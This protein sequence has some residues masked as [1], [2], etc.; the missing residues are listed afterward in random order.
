[1]GHIARHLHGSSHLHLAWQLASV[2]WPGTTSRYLLLPKEVFVHAGK[3]SLVGG[4]SLPGKERMCGYK[5]TPSQ[6]DQIGPKACLLG[7]DIRMSTDTCKVLYNLMRLTVCMY[8]CVH[9]HFTLVNNQHSTNMATQNTL[10]Y[11]QHNILIIRADIL[12]YTN[13]AYLRR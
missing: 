5:Q 11:L 6:V 1:M 2:P 3:V 9:I 7:Q 12:P 10:N 4:L 8:R 13:R